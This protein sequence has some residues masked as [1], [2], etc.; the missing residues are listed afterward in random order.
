MTITTYY[1]AADTVLDRLIAMVRRRGPLTTPDLAEAAL[2]A[3]ARLDPDN[4][5]QDRRE[6]L[7]AAVLATAVQRLIHAAENT[8]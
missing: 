3:L 2:E 8:P 6:K 7:L 5:E 4:C 1:A